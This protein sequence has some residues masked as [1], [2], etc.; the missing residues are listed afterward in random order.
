[1]GCNTTIYNKLKD[2][3]IDDIDIEEVG[4]GEYKGKFTYHSYVWEVEVKVEDGEVTDIEILQNRQNY[5]GIKAQEVL[6]R[7]IDEQSLNVDSV[8]G[9]SNSSKGLLKAT[10]DA[11][12]KGL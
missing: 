8:S 4:D 3:E 9:A 2:M 5:H 7:V 10:E 6:Q 12:E 11:L 1:M